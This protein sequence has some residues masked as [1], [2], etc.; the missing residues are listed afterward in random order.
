MTFLSQRAVQLKT[1]YRTHIDVIGLRFN[2]Y[3][4]FFF[5]SLPPF[6]FKFSSWFKTRRYIHSECCFS[7]P[8]NLSF[9]VVIIFRTNCTTY[10]EILIC[11]KIEIEFCG[12]HHTLFVLISTNERLH[13]ESII[14]TNIY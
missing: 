2:I 12:K 11:R 13:P 3:I 5:Y 7:K 9:N 8:K 1:S 10:V 14:R 6:S 4:S